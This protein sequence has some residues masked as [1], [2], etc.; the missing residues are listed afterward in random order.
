MQPAIHGNPY[1]SF[2][3]SRL[4]VYEEGLGSG[5]WAYRLQELCGHD[6][7]SRGSGIHV[8]EG[9]ASKQAPRGVCHFDF[10]IMVQRFTVR[11]FKVNLV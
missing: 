4:G 9:V 5:V 3:I 8:C 1:V 2:G 10:G 11:L 6:T 7:V